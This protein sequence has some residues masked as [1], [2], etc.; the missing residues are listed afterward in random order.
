MLRPTLRLS[1]LVASGL[2]LT[3]CATQSYT[4][5]AS[6]SELEARNYDCGQLTREFVETRLIQKEIS[7]TGGINLNTLRAL[8][9]DYGLGNL[10]ARS[11]A[12]EAAGERLEQIRLTLAAKGCKPVIDEPDEP[13]NS[14]LSKVS[15][16][17]AVK[18][19][20]RLIRGN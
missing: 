19:A 9:V 15:E 20:G 12:R 18:S 8:P 5:V 6:F 11:D 14:F 7:K 2:A 3:A 1:A 16:N 13:D 17:S 4:T 10:L